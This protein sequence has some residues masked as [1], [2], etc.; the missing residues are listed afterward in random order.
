MES[1]PPYPNKHTG[2]CIVAGSAWCLEDDLERARS[3]IGDVPVVAVNGAAS[4]VKAVMLVSQHPDRFEVL[5]WRRKQIALYGNAFT[6]HA[7]GTGGHGVDYWWPIR[8]GGGSAWC[9]RKIASLVGFSRVILCGCPMEPGPYVG[10]HNLGG[11]MHRQDVVD[12]LMSQIERDSQWHEGA[13]S[14]S[15]KTRALLGEPC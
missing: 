6:T 2:T 3:L 8:K 15:G 10:N 4:L 7:P 11:F 9:A 1:I 14:M 12:E 13:C 5:G